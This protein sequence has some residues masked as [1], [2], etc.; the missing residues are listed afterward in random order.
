MQADPLNCSCGYGSRPG[1]AC[2]AHQALDTASQTALSDVS[3]EPDRATRAGNVVL[4]QV[5]VAGN[6]EHAR[7]MK[8]PT[9]PL[10]GREGNPFFE[11][12]LLQ[13]T[14]NGKPMSSVQLMGYWC[15]ELHLFFIPELAGV[16]RKVKLASCSERSPAHDQ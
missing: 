14:S 9:C 8:P 16:E 12:S 4:A 6:V 5:L 3:L 1:Q 2:R 11:D 13:L 7:M 15:G 10:C